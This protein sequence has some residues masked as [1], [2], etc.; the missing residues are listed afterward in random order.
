MN[1]I[2]VRKPHLIGVFAGGVRMFG[3]T[4]RVEGQTVV[5]NHQSL[6][7]H[8]DQYRDALKMD[9]AE[10]GA[11]LDKLSEMAAFVAHCPPVHNKN[12]RMKDLNN[13]VARDPNA[14]R[15][16]RGG[17]PITAANIFDME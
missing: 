13:S 16:D 10:F 3:V 6:V 1:A 11:I 12:I 2:L 14:P 15:K 9:E 7:A 5:V 17:V 4:L 8:A